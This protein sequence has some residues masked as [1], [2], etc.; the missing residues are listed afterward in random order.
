MLA[1]QE[2]VPQP[3]L[4]RQGLELLHHRRRAVARC[5]IAAMRL[6]AVQVL[7]R[8]HM[9]VHEVIDLLAQGGGALAVLEVH[10]CLRWAAWVSRGCHKP[11]DTLADNPVMSSFDDDTHVAPLG[12]VSDAAGSAAAFAGQVD[13]AWNIGANPNG[14]YLLA[15]AAQA[16]RQRTPAQ[17]D[18]L[19]ITVHYLRPGLSG[20]PCHI[21]T[22]L[23]RSGR[24]LSTVRGTLLQDGQPR[25][26]LLAAMGHLGEPD[27]APR[28]C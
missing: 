15:L 18:P 22:Q 11:G 6:L 4:A 28:R 14:G 27:A 9:P 26:E 1:G 12:P 25:L 8:K 20:Q 7:H 24:T 3:L 2:Q 5:R 19:S 23:L 13:P 21:D 17:P 10:A 16:M